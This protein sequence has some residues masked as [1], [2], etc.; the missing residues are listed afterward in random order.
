M[1][2]QRKLKPD[3]EAFGDRFT[4]K[5]RS[6]SVES[7]QTAVNGFFVFMFRRRGREGPGLQKGSSV[8]F[9][10]GVTVVVGFAFYV[11]FVVCRCCFGGG[12]LV[13]TQ[14]IKFP[15]V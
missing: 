10:P 15:V 4:L 6:A 11:C 5:V 14:P 8:L 9:R 2:F 12:C 3:T 7:R 13:F 1:F